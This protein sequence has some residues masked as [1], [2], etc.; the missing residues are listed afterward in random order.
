MNEK[1]TRVLAFLKDL[2]Y[3]LKN[4]QLKSISPILNEHNLEASI[5]T[6]LKIMGVIEKTGGVLYWIY[7]DTDLKSLSIDVDANNR[8]YHINQSK[9]PLFKGFMQLEE[10]ENPF[11]VP[12]NEVWKVL[13]Y[14]VKAKAKKS[15]Y[16]TFNE[17][18]DFIIFDLKVEN[19]NENTGVSD[20]G[21]R[22]EENIYLSNKC[23]LKF[24]MRAQTPLGKQFADKIGDLV[25]EIRN[26]DLKHKKHTL[27]VFKE[28]TKTDHI[29][30]AIDLLRKYNQSLGENVHRRN[31]ADPNQ[32]SLEFNDDLH[33]QSILNL[34]DKVSE[35]IMQGYPVKMIESNEKK[36][37]QLSIGSK[38][39]EVA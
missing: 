20:V 5:G 16:Q 36:R 37:L 3:R 14:S 21:G 26:N 8:A 35:L 18:I 1:Q 33:W 13:G 15:L 23:F 19:P 4:E 38:E 28:A 25:Y 17:N 7:K 6:V 32:L 12:F 2:E 22:P 27:N 9:M 30:E 39:E 11:P 31:T 34:R 24:C 29:Q 10:E